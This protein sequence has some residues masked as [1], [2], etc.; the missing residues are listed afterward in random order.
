M[1]K[2]PDVFLELALR[3]LERVP[4][5]LAGRTLEAYLADELCQSAVERQLEVAGDAL[6]QIRK[7]HP[8]LFARIPGGALVVAFRNVLA[9]GYATLDHARVYDA[10]THKVPAL[11][12][13]IRT[14]LDSFPAARAWQSRT[15]RGCDG[16][17]VT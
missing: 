10:A 13:T 3:A 16:R 12:A 1:S 7:L 8:E 9:L 2:Q 15:G 5:F 14:L 17:I 11:T 4:R 6:G